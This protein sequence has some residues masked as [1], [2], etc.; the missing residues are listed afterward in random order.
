MIWWLACRNL[1]S[2]LFPTQHHNQSVQLKKPTHGPRFFLS[3]FLPF[4]FGY[5][6]ILTSRSLFDNHISFHAQGQAIFAS[7]SPFEPVEY[8]GKLLVPGQVGISSSSNFL[9]W[10]TLFH[11]K[12]TWTMGSYFSSLSPS[13]Q[14]CLHISWFR[15]GTDHL[16]CHSRTGWNAFGSL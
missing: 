13:G 12:L 9:L 6:A 1:L 2:L 15:F 11:L 16:W 7:G 10:I 14:Q 3:Y 8:E 4:F 5:G